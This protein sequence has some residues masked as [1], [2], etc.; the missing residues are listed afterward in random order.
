MTSWEKSI[1]VFEK[2]DFAFTVVSVALGIASLVG[3]Y[4]N[5]RH[6]KQIFNHLEQQCGVL[7]EEKQ[8]VEKAIPY[9]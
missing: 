1:S 4:M 8:R 9:K 6:T 7:L 5:Y 2:A 3:V